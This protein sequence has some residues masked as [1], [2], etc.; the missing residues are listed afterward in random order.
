MRYLDTKRFNFSFFTNGTLIS[1]DYI[2]Q[3]ND[4]NHLTYIG[5]SIDGASQQTYQRIRPNADLPRVLKNLS[6]LQNDLSKHIEIGIHYTVTKYNYEEI[7]DMVILAKRIGV[8]K[9]SFSGLYLNEYCDPDL[10]VSFWQ[11]RE[12]I[13]VDKFYSISNEMDIT[14]NLRMA[15]LGQPIKRP[16]CFMPFNYIFIRSNG[17][18]QP[19]C[20]ITNNTKHSMGNIFQN[21]LS[22]IW[23]NELYKNFRKL[24]WYGNPDICKKCYVNDRVQ[25]VKIDRFLSL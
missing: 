21:N 19:C 22:E 2:C 23:N 12:T 20:M 6:H 24:M 18:I 1:E 8:K 9:V 17:N 14:F 10:D 11:V 25:L 4:F 16:R 13:D 3:L 5:L 7:V 15:P